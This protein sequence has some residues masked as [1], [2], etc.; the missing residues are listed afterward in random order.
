MQTPA[1]QNKHQT[2]AI[3]YLKEMRPAIRRV[4]MTTAEPL[5]IG[6]VLH[7]DPDWSKLPA[8][9]PRLVR[10]LLT[11]CLAKDRRQRLQELLLR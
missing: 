11:R 2:V 6:A 10:L 7:K 8:D 1:N 9:T 5:Y 4:G 3:G